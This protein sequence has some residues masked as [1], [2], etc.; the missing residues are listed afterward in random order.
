MTN[1]KLYQARA[2][3]NQRNVDGLFYVDEVPDEDEEDYMEIIFKSDLSDQLY[4]FYYCDN[5]DLDLGM[6]IDTVQKFDAFLDDDNKNLDIKVFPVK[7]V[8]KQITVTKYVGEEKW[9]HKKLEHIL[10]T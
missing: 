2:L 5:D 4:S 9:W 6:T 8:T 7:K 1:I 3:I 10:K